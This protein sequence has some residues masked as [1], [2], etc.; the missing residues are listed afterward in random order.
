[1]L[2]GLL[3]P[4]GWGLP[5]LM[6]IR[7]PSPS[8][9]LH[10]ASAA[11]FVVGLFLTLRKPAPPRQ[12]PE[13]LIRFGPLFFS[14]PLALFGM[15]HFVFLD[16]VKSAV[17]SWMP[18]H[19]FWAV[20]VGTAL[21]AAGF[22]LITGIRAGLAALLVGIMLFLFVLMIY[23][24]NLFHDPHNRFAIT[25]PLRDL[26][27]SGGALSLAGF[28]GVTATP[29]PLPWL[30]RIGL[31]FFSAP[32]LYF[33]VEHFLHPQFAP[34]APFPL[35][36]PSW[37]P[38]HFI[39]AYATGTLLLV[40]GLCLLFGLRARLA[41]ALVGLTWLLL[42]LLVYLPMEIVHPSILIGGELD[43][44]ADTLALSG[45]ALLVAAAI[46]VATAPARAVALAETTA[47]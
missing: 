3:F 32:L 18:G 2:P 36:M 31:W 23:L 37:I 27:L 35:R 10:A 46:P 8:L 34:G 38:G 14:V 28:L 7:W 39:W 45:A 1:V 9:C 13:R 22:S 24:P 12:G 25:V 5:A 4:C 33:G 21:I 17:P 16:E 40:C 44:V 42:V 43:Y 41:A 26:T 19:L 47:A 30:S 15:Q 11:L 29:R 6:A 20:L